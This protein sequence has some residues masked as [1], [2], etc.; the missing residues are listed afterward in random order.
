MSTQ[1]FKSGIQEQKALKHTPAE[2]DDQGFSSMLA[3]KIYLQQSF[4]F[5]DFAITLFGG[6]SFRKRD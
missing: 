2:I 1:P 6:F 4:H 3:E 5:F